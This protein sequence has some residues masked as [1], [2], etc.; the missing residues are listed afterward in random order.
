MAETVPQSQQNGLA[1]IKEAAKNNHVLA[2]EYKIYYDIRFGS[3]TNLPKLEEALET[4]ANTHKSTRAANTLAEFSHAQKD[5]SEDF[6]TKAARYYGQSANSG[7]LIGMFHL[8][9]Y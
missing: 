1:W 4:A 8:G 7:C 2:T 5:K 6:K 3:I 9:C